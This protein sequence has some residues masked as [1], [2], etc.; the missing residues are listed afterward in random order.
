M[1]TE[2]GMGN[3]KGNGKHGGTGRE[4]GRRTAKSQ[5]TVFCQ[6]GQK[7]AF[8]KSETI[9]PCPVGKS[10]NGIWNTR[11]EVSYE[12]SENE[13]RSARHLGHKMKIE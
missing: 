11:L 8:E 2:V 13:N 3:G 10:Q 9:R 4:N 1:E 5:K 6:L 7:T 12:F